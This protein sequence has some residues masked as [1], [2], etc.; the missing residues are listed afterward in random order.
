MRLTD[1]SDYSLRTLI[2]LNRE[3]RLVTMNELAEK[4]HVSRNHLIKVVV[5]LTRAGYVESVRGRSGG[6]EIS[7][8]AGSLKLGDILLTTEEGFDLAE[9]FRNPDTECPFFP[10][11]KLKKTLNHALD[12][13]ISTLNQ[14]TLDDVT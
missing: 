2:Y 7:P 8:R 3:Q 4:L 1:F 12:A 13:F 5:R 10:S 9:C 14:Q 11:C 6:L